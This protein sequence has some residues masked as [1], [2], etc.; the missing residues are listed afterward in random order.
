MGS[1]R[2]AVWRKSVKMAPQV[3]AFDL[4]CADEAACAHLLGGECAGNSSTG[5]H[6]RHRSSPTDTEEV[7]FILV[8]RQTRSLV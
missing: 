4:H 3:F 6:V 7:V 5:V 8:A 1:V 2:G